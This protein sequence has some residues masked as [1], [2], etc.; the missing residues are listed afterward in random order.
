MYVDSPPVTT[1]RSADNPR[2]PSA[3]RDA[4]PQTD[5]SAGAARLR[6]GTVAARRTRVADAI[7][8]QWLLEQLPSDHRHALRSA[9]DQRRELP[10]RLRR[11]GPA[12]RR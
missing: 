7:V 4:T 6:P 5:A 12:K 11:R 8:S 9:S 3:R 1:R 2:L 10:V